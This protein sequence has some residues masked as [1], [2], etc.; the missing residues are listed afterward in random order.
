[1]SSIVAS[2]NRNLIVDLGIRGIHHWLICTLQPV[3]VG[4][5][6]TAQALVLCVHMEKVHSLQLEDNNV[7][8]NFNH[9]N[10]MR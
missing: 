5:H 2:A 9:L 6:C 10:T 3:H 1:M 7:H 4:V 8:C